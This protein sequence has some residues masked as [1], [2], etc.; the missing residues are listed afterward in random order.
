M[1]THHFWIHNG[2]FAPNNFFCGKIMN[3]IFIHL[4]APFIVKNFKKVLAADPE[5]WG[6]TIF[7]TING[8]FATMRL[9][10]FLSFMPVYVPNIKVR[11][12]SIKEILMIKEYWNLIGQEKFSTITWGQDFCQAFSLHRMLMNHKNSHFKTIP[13]KTHDIILNHVFGPFWTI[14]RHFCPT[15][16]Y[17]KKPASVPPNY[18][19][20]LNTMLSF[21]KN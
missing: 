9:F 10:F 19:W 4:L 12:W 6:C 11:W 21:R 20:A 17:F 15:A 2:P 13:E 14:F 5:L 16:I 8:L 1:R 7:W 18:I 3:I